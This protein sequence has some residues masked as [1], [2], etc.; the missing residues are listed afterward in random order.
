MKKNEA[1]Y[2]RTN[3]RP[4]AATLKSRCATTSDGG[5]SA[6]GHDHQPEA[7]P[8]TG[9]SMDRTSSITTSDVQ[10][11]GTHRAQVRQCRPARAATSAGNGGVVPAA[12]FTR[13]RIWPTACANRTK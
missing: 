3:S 1:T 2:D 4:Y 9:L 13:V 6:G 11:T 10:I 7:Q 8:K 12:G 5:A